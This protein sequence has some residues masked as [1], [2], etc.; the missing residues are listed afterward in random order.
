MSSG[1]L[2]KT[3]YG[4]YRWSFAANDEAT[5]AGGRPCIA[6]SDDIE[7]I[8]V[9]VCEASLPIVGQ[10]RD[11]EGDG[12]CKFELPASRAD[13]ED[14][15]S[16]EAMHLTMLA[17]QSDTWSESISVP[18]DLLPI[19]ALQEDRESDTS[20]DGDGRLSGGDAV[21][22]HHDDLLRRSRGAQALIDN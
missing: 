21:G 14:D 12:W 10:W 6:V 4:P 16:A 15:L 17:S 22:E 5:L 20:A 1:T 3:R 2:A 13:A 11:D 7:E 9:D 19:H 8:L 18:G